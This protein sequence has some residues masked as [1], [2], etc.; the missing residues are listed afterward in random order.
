MSK[1]GHVVFLFPDTDFRWGGRVRGG[2]PSRDVG[3]TWSQGNVTM[4]RTGGPYWRCVG[5]SIRGVIQNTRPS[6]R[7]IPQRYLAPVTYIG[8]IVYHRKVHPHHM[9]EGTRRTNGMRST[10]NARRENITWPGTARTRGNRSTRGRGRAGGPVVAVYGRR[11]R[12]GAKRRPSARSSSAA[13]IASSPPAISA[14][15][16]RARR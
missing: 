4:L 7:R 5:R 3:P 2:G 12:R 16:W 11:E 9:N 15:G 1:S 8:P 10:G 13:V 6:M 14:P